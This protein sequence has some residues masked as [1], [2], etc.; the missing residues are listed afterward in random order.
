MPRKYVR[1]TAV[2]TPDQSA[3]IAV[4]ERQLSE[5]RSENA[6][7]RVAPVS[8]SSGIDTGDLQIGP[9]D[10]DVTMS[11]AGKMEHPD[12]QVET[13]PLNHEKAAELAFMEELMTVRVADTTDPEEGVCISVWN[14][15][16]HQLFIRGQD[17]TCKRKFVEVLARAK[18]TS[19]ANVE[20]TESDGS[21]SIKWPKRT[22]AR[23]PF[24]VVRDDNPRGP[25]WLRRVLMQP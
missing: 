24:Q 7:L 12:I 8:L 3:S 20:F 5:A 15:G 22:G 25:E 4:L 16:R 18:P 10:G 2:P 17:V 21:R 13:K 11:Q 9:G 19:Y 23:Y 14:W 6:R 1:K